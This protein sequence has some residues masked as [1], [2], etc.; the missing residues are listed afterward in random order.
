MFVQADDLSVHDQTARHESNPD[1]CGKI[2]ERCEGMTVAGI[3]ST[4]PV[5]NDRKR[6]EA[7]V[8]QL[9]QISLIIEWERLSAQ[10]H[11]LEKLAFLPSL[12]EGWTNKSRRQG[13]L[14][15]RK[16]TITKKTNYQKNHCVPHGKRISY[17][18]IWGVQ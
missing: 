13:M 2:C 16:R 4:A 11:W 1:S 15:L 6:S 18:A 9:K 12:A 7:V 14:S 17:S 3:E 5:F 8:L 10:R